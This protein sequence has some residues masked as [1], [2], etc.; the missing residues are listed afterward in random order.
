MERRSREVDVPGSATL[1]RADC[2]MV[3]RGRPRPGDRDA[4]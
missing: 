3:P 1:T 4:V 2:G